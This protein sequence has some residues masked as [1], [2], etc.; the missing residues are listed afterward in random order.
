VSG[1]DIGFSLFS[2][3]RRSRSTV[4]E[5]RTRQPKRLASENHG[6]RV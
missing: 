1:V 2:A 5:Y 3:N 4:F 6:K